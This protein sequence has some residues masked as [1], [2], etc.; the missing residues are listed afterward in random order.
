[1]HTQNANIFRGFASIC[2]LMHVYVF[3]HVCFYAYMYLYTLV[4]ACL[5]FCACVW[6]TCTCERVMYSCALVVLCLRGSWCMRAY[7]VASACAFS[8][9]MCTCPLLR[10]LVCIVHT[11]VHARISAAPRSNRRSESYMLHKRL[12]KNIFSHCCF[13]NACMR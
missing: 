3:I 12:L 10:R 5:R 2:L 11:N 9:R 7:Q 1:M 4:H 6:C 13:P 8:S